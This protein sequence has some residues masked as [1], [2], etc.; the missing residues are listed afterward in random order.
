MTLEVVLTG[1]NELVVNAH[2]KLTVTILSQDGYFI[3]YKSVIHV[4]K[5]EIPLPIIIQF[6]SELPENSIVYAMID[7]LNKRECPSLNNGFN[8]YQMSFL[9]NDFNTTGRKSLRIWFEVPGYNIKE[10]VQEKFDF[11]VS[12]IERQV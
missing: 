6:S 2:R 3:P 10:Y 12:N 9:P 1:I 8:Q 4:V 11:I 7:G 5:N